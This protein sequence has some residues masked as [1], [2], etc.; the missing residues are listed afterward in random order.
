MGIK[1]VAKLLFHPKSTL[2]QPLKPVFPA[3]STCPWAYK[4]IHRSWL[5][6]TFLGE[7]PRLFQ[8]TFPVVLS[9][10]TNARMQACQI[11]TQT[12]SFFQ[13]VNFSNEQRCA[14][15]WQRSKE[16]VSAGVM[17]EVSG[18]PVPGETGSR[19]QSTCA[20]DASF[21]PGSTEDPGKGFRVPGR[22]WRHDSAAFD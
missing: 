13:R 20:R 14:H 22:H 6:I 2:A 4:P 21:E 18:C 3:L 12:R 7:Q 16:N 8:A 17:D 9:H 10:E 19:L 15:I 1:P 5:L 11:T